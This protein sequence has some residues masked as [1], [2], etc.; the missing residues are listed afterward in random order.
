[1]ETKRIVLNHFRCLQRALGE[2]DGADAFLNVKT[3]QVEVRFGDRAHQLIPSFSAKIDGRELYTPKLLPEVR[4]FA[5]WRPYGTN[6]RPILELSK[7]L[8]FKKFLKE[9]KFNYPATGAAFPCELDA[10]LIKRDVS[11]FSE[12]IRGPFRS[13]SDVKPESATGE[14][15]E[16]FIA[17]RIVKA[18]FYNATPVCFEIKPMPSITGDG[19]ST[20]RELVIK[21]MANM[22]D[23]HGRP[24][25]IDWA[26]IADMLAFNN[27]TFDSVLVKGESRP[28]DY[29]YSS[30]CSVP[31]E[32][33]EVI[34]PVLPA[35][36]RYLDVE[37]LSKLGLAIWDE[38]PPIWRSA[39]IYAVDAICD[40][41]GQFWFLEANFHPFVH[42]AVYP[43]M[44][45]GWT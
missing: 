40:S 29:R 4:M 41:T 19:E 30:W 1:M 5:G 39:A 32:V 25:P 28:I 26:S 35:E 14:F 9:N 17:G 38:F 45:A 44:I 31:I 8:T 33:V 2:L 18:W 24:V 23:V 27:Y 10:F 34:L 11:S 15:F 21:K 3:F 6:D 13:G 22:W 42:P 16:Q 36:E 7:K 37:P 12:N 20:A 43:L